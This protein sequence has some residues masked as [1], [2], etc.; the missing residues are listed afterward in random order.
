MARIEQ[1]GARKLAG[2]G[3]GATQTAVP[4]GRSDPTHRISAQPPGPVAADSASELGCSVA[5]G[6][7]LPGPSWHGDRMVSSKVWGPEL[8]SLAQAGVPLSGLTV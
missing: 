1:S 2:A 8:V 4:W 5:T 7:T 6:H 3:Q